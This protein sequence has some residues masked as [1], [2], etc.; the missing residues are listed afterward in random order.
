ME[1]QFLEIGLTNEQELFISSVRESYGFDAG[2]Y[3][4]GRA[5]SVKDDNDWQDAKQYAAGMLKERVDILKKAVEHEHRIPVSLI[6][7]DPEDFPFP[8][9]F[10]MDEKYLDNIKWMIAAYGN[11]AGNFLLG[12]L[13]AAKTYDE[14]TLV[15]MN[16]ANLDKRF[17]ELPEEQ[18]GIRF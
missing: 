14:R 3:L 16:A 17:T 6:A 4:I 8:P 1:R 15:I 10:D 18:D 12:G 7:H 5:L 2:N 11:E 9:R 13:V